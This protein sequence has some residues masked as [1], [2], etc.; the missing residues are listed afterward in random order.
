MLAFVL[1]STYDFIR[2]GVFPAVLVIAALGIIY[3]VRGRGQSQRPSVR[4][5]VD[6]PPGSDPASYLEGRLG[7]YR[8]AASRDPSKMP[9]LAMR[10]LA[11]SYLY[12]E[13]DP[14]RSRS[15]LE[16]ALEVVESESYPADE[17]ADLVKG[18]MLATASRN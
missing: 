3:G 7:Q 6:A 17:E 11:L 2:Y 14:E 9:Q 12:R 1:T 18:A 16:E 10:L 15:Y 13:R 5:L 8:E 4:A